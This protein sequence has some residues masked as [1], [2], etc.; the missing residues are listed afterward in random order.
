MV[1]GIAGTCA[2]LF[3][4][5]LRGFSAKNPANAEPCAKS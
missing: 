3:V 1:G 5:M 2:F 4:L